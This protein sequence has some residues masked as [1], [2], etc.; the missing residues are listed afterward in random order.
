M[1]ESPGMLLNSMKQSSSQ[2]RCS[3][4]D[5]K[6]GWNLWSYTAQQTGF[7]CFV[8]FSCN[9][10]PILKAEIFED[11][12]LSL[13]FNIFPKLFCLFL[14]MNVITAWGSQDCNIFE[15][16]DGLW[17]VLKFPEGLRFT[18]TKVKSHDSWR[19]DKE[20][21]HSCFVS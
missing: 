14:S 9:W 11:K 19:P 21:Y 18:V 12:L 20:G 16:L 8:F 4:Q 2:W 1:K 6:T 13:F 3:K 5:E 17:S 7:C 15:S 10:N